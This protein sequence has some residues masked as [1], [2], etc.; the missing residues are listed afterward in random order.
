[1]HTPIAEG[2]DVPSGQV[3][4]HVGLSGF[5]GLTVAV[6]APVYGLQAPKSGQY[7]VTLSM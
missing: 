6:N 3:R 2:S 1:M 5:R 7:V 4:N